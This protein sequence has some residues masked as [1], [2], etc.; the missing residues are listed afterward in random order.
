MD[1]IMVTS[2]P[3]PIAAQFGRGPD[4]CY[5]LYESGSG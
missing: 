4:I 5:S 2:S 1:H 3:F